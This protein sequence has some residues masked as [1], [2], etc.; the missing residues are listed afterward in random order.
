MIVF[1]LQCPSGH[2]FEG[3]FSSSE[4]FSSQKERG[5][6]CCPQCG[7]VDVTKAP[8]APAV[9]AKGA[10]K[11]ERAGA[12]SENV[13]GGVMPPELAEA[14][15]KVA[16][17]QAE[18]LKQSEWV[19]DKFAEKSRAMHYGEQDVKPIHGRTTTEQAKE[20]HDEGIPVAPLLVPFVPPDEVN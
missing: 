5:L 20:L 13:A 15:R 14:F 4:D 17:I 6:I 10:Q 18:A 7:T 9:P 12:K 11:Q 16:A 8:M 1:D 2:R 3:W 19:G